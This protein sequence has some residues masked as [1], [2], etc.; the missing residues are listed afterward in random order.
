[1]GK[2][3]FTL[4][5]EIDV[6]ENGRPYIKFAK[7]NIDHPEHKFMALEISRYLLLGLLKDNEEAHDLTP[8]TEVEI[9]RA[10]DAL[11]Q[12]ADELAR[13]I[14]EQMDVMDDLGLDV[15]EDDV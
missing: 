7:D 13:L 15:K 6:N 8:Q 14:K 1:M 4:K 3:N 5:Y 10:E 9:I 11:R 12:I 2:N